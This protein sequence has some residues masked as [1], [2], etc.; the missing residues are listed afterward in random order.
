[1]TNNLQERAKIRLTEK[2]N[3][4]Q[5][6]LIKALDNCNDL[7]LD[8]IAGKIR[9]LEAEKLN[10]TIQLKVDRINK[11]HKERREILKTL[12]SFGPIDS[13][14][15]TNDRKLNKS[16]RK[17]NPELY[18]FAD[19][20]PYTSFSFAYDGLMEI[21]VKRNKYK[22]QR[23]KSGG[24]QEPNETIDFENFEQACSYNNILPK[25]KTFKQ[26]KKELA[27]IDQ[28]TAKL[29]A[30]IEKNSEDLKKTDYYFL[31][32]NGFLSRHN[33]SAYEYNTNKS[34]Q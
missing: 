26:V 30:Q 9:T 27:K 2:L 4:L 8:Q 23:V 21:N 18:K 5:T 29:Q 14:L 11:D 3:K 32:S 33:V 19:E 25:S 24:Y 34:M 10:N 6:E 13:D 15:I 28:I 20:N 7:E 22:V 16:K 12:L 1:M 17:S 31:E